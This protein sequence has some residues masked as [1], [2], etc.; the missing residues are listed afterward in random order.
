MAISR[1][2]AVPWQ[3]LRADLAL[4]AIARV[5]EGA[6]AEREIDRTLRG[7]RGL[8]REE[9]TA[10]VEAIFGVALWRR[11][12]AWHA[13]T[14]EPS[15][16]LSAL[17]GFGDARQREAPPRLADRW[18]LPDWLEQHLESELGG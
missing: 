10:L 5:L 11:R 17:I 6:A 1:L 18:S 12:L 4:P 3:A 7:N 14:S 8:S 13:G 15:A 2:R 16:L 9:R